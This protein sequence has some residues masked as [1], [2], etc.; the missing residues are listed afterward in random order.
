MHLMAAHDRTYPMI[1]KNMLNK[2]AVTV[3]ATVPLALTLFAIVRLWGLH[4]SWLDVSLLLGFHLL[5][6]LG[7]TLGYHR[8]TTHGAFKARRPVQAI[9]V[10]MGVNA[11]PRAA[12]PVLGGHPPAATTASADQPGDPHSPLEGLWHA[13]M[14]LDSSRATWSTAAPASNA[15]C[16]TPSMRFFEKTQF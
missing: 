11:H 12:P 15:S 16:A 10:W 8:M 5:G 6:G 14:G 1:G 9:L 4:V 13:H 3:V 7:I 2:V